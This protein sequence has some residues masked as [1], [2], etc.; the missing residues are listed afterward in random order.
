MLAEFLIDLRAAFE[1]AD[2]WAIGPGLRVGV[3]GCHAASAT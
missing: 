2:R 1:R 3:S